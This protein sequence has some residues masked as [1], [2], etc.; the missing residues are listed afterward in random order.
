MKRQSDLSCF[1][2]PQSK[3]SKDVL[4]SESI[5]MVSD[6]VPSLDETTSTST[7]SNGT[8][9]TIDEAL[10]SAFDIGLFINRNDLDQKTKSDLLK[11]IWKP[12]ETYSFE[13]DKYKRKFQIQWFNE[14]P[15]LEF[16]HTKG[17]AFCR[18]CVLF[19]ANK[20]DQAN[21]ECGQLVKEPYTNNKVS[22]S[23][24]AKYR[25]C[26]Q[27]ESFLVSKS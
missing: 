11:S 13:P 1:L 18:C 25:N 17:G 16:S 14:F 27:T 24:R 10:I 21:K 9:G 4:D 22:F 19:L 5:I 7:D 20:A 6:S 23:M 12:T 8:N 15:W 2:Q 26:W 3:K